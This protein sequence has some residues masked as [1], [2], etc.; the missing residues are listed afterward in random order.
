MVAT[1][2]VVV[3]VAITHPTVIPDLHVVFVT[4]PCGEI[5]VHLVYAP[6][7]VTCE[8]CGGIH[9]ETL[10]WVSG[11]RRFT[12]ALMVT[13]VTWARILTSRQVT[14]LFHCAWSTVAA[15]VEE[16]VAYGLD[17]RDLL[18]V[19]HICI[20]EISRKRG[21]VYVTNIYDLNAG[22]CCGAVMV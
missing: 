3:S 4:C 22:V 18:G 15:A 14:S 10:P 20:D 16:A 11:K 17:H 9:V 7:R 2:L 6:R 13:L 8:H 12:R 21:H 1:P 19:T 5:D